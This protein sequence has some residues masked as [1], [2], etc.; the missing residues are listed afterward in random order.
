[1]N[2]KN[3]APYDEKF[4]DEVLA[5]TVAAWSTVLDR[6]GL[7]HLPD[8]AYDS[9][10]PEGWQVR[11]TSDV[12]ALL[13]NEPSNIWLALLDGQLVGFIGIRIHLKDSMG[14][15]YIIAVSP[16]H[17]RQGIGRYLIEHA[18]NLIR[19]AGMKMVM[20]E[21]TGD[22]GHERARLTYESAGY[23]QWPITRYFKSLK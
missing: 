21:T 22:S 16:N 9:F 2:E 12:E 15:I 11:Q 18:E 5:L 13:A 14:E 3:I 10:F 17:H 20:I 4:H 1:M 19:N 8:Y 6:S 7:D 23:I